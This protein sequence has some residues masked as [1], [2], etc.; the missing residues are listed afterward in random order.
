MATEIDWDAVQPSEEGGEAITGQPIPDASQIDWDSVRPYNPDDS[1]G[2]RQRL[3]FNLQNDYQPDQGS[4]YDQAVL[5]AGEGFARLPGVVGGLA[6]FAGA[7]ETGRNLSRYSQ[8]K[9]NEYEDLAD[10]LGT[11]PAASMARSLGETTAEFAPVAAAGALGSAVGGE[12][13]GRIAMSAYGG[14]QSL[15]EVFDQAQQAYQQNGLSESAA[16]SKARIPAA[17]AGAISAALNYFVPGGA[18]WV[19]ENLA[20]G[21]LSKTETQQILR[22]AITEAAGLSGLSASDALS[23]GVIAKLSYDPERTLKEIAAQTGMAALSGAGLGLLMSGAGTVSKGIA[24]RRTDVFPAEG[25]I[26]PESQGPT[27]SG[28][29]I[30]NYGP[31]ASRT[32]NRFQRAWDDFVNSSRQAW[33]DLNGEGD[34]EHADRSNSYFNQERENGANQQQGQSQSNQQGSTPRPEPVFTAEKT[35]TTPLSEADQP[36]ITLARKILGAAG[37]ADDFANEAARH[38]VGLFE[39][40]PMEGAEQFRERL[41]STL[42]DHGVRPEKDASRRKRADQAKWNASILEQMRARA[43]TPVG[44]AQTQTPL[45]P[46]QSA[47]SPVETNQPIAETR[48]PIRET[49]VAPIETR[50]LNPEAIPARPVETPNVPLSPADQFG[51]IHG[52]KLDP[53]AADRLRAMHGEFLTLP[54]IGDVE[55]KV[56]VSGSH[57]I[58]TAS[59]PVSKGSSSR[60]VGTAVL[61]I[62]PDGSTILD[63]SHQNREIDKLSQDALVKVIT[64]QNLIQ[65]Q[66]SPSAPPEVSPVAPPVKQAHVDW[67]ASTP[68][69]GVK[70]AGHYD[71]IDAKDL[72]TSF[73]RGFDQSLQPRDRARTASQQ[74]IVDIAQ[75]LDPARLGDA[76]T[77]DFGAPITDESNQVLSGNGRASALRRAFE[78]GG[79]QAASYRQW[80]SE[81]ASKFGID[82]AKIASV[83][84]PVLVR[85]V[86]DLGGLTK[87]QFA[88]QSNRQQ[89][90]GKSEAV[91]AASDARM[92]LSNP[93]LMEAFRPSE[94]GDVLAA[95]NRDFLKSFVMGTGDQAALM[96]RNE[97][98][99]PVLRKRVRNAV[100]GALIGPENRATITALLER[101]EELGLSNAVNGLMTAAPALLRLSGTQ[102]D[103]SGPLGKATQDLVRL[104]SEGSKV[105]DFLS[106]NDLFGDPDRSGESDLILMQ[107]AKSKSAKAVAE[108]LAK[109]ALRA[110]RIDTSTPDIFG[111][112]NP[113]RGEMLKTAYEQE[114]KPIS[115]DQ[116]D[117]PFGKPSP[118]PSTPNPPRENPRGSIRDQTYPTSTTQGNQPVLGRAA[119]IPEAHA[120]IDQHLPEAN[121]APM[122]MALDALEKSGLDTSKFILELTQTARDGLAGSFQNGLMR[123]ATDADPATGPEE[124]YHWMIESLPQADQAYLEA[125]RLATMPKDA[126]E[127]IRA[128]TMSTKEFQR[129]GLPEEMYPWI[130]LHEY[131][132]HDFADKT[133]SDALR[134]KN[135]GLWQRLKDWFAKLWNALKS[136]VRDPAASE[137]IYQDIQNGTQKYDPAKRAEAAERRGKFVTKKTELESAMDFAKGPEAKKIESE[138]ALAQVDA[139]VKLMEKHGVPDLPARVRRAL[140]YSELKGI[141]EVGVHGNGAHDDYYA[142]RDRSSDWLKQRLGVYAYRHAVKFEYDLTRASDDGATARA[143]LNSPEIRDEISEMQSRH[144]SALFYEQAFKNAQVAIKTAL[145][146]AMELLKQERAS[147]LRQA[148]LEAQIRTL[149]EVGESRIALERLLDDMTSVLLSTPQGEWILKNGGTSEDIGKIYRDIKRST[150]QTINS[151]QMI[152]VASYLLSRMPDLR[153]QLLAAEY[154]KQNGPLAAAWAKLK[155]LMD[156]LHKNPAATIERMM[157]QREKLAADA[158]AAEFIFRQ[159]AKE[160]TKKLDTIY[161]R[162]KTGEVARNILNDPEFKKYLLDTQRDSG[163]YGTEKPLEPTV[164]EGPGSFYVTPDNRRVGNLANDLRSGDQKVIEKRYKQAQADLKIYNEWL[165]NPANSQ[166]PR[167]EKFLMERNS[168]RDYWGDHTLLTPNH[169][170]NI[171]NT[172]LSSIDGTIAYAGGRVAPQNRKIAQVLNRTT[173]ATQIWEQKSLSDFQKTRIAGIKSHG[174][175]WND[176]TGRDMAWANDRYDA[177][178]QELA[179]KSQFRTGALKLGDKTASGMT[180]TQEDLDALATQSRLDGEGYKIVQKAD[181]QVTED[182]QGLPK[183]EN[184]D[185]MVIYRRASPVTSTTLPRIPKFDALPKAI[186]TATAFE[187]YVADKTPGNLSGLIDA[188][189]KIWP[190]HGDSLISHRESDFSHFTIFDGEGGAFEAVSKEISE[191]TRFLDFE[192]AALRIADISG[193]RIDEVRQIMAEEFGSIVANLVKELHRETQTGKSTIVNGGDPTNSFT[194]ERG[195]QL[196]PWTFYQT[197]WSSVDD[198][199]ATG[200]HMIS[201]ALNRMLMGLE[202]Q[203]SDLNRQ[204][205]DFEARTAQL[206]QQGAWHPKGAAQRENIRSGR[207]KQTFDYWFRLSYRTDA[208]RIRINEI[209]NHTTPSG[210]MEGFGY[211][212]DRYATAATQLLIS[213]E[214]TML[215]NIGIVYPYRA[216][217]AMGNSELLSVAAIFGIGTKQALKMLA[218]GYIPTALKLPF[219]TVWKGL[220]LGLLNSLKGKGVSEVIFKSV[221]REVWKELALTSQKRIPDV[222]EMIEAGVHVPSASEDDYNNKLASAFYRQ[223][224]K[225]GERISPTQKLFLSPL[226]SIEASILPV[227]TAKNPSMGDAVVNSIAWNFLHSSFSPNVVFK[228]KV[229]VLMKRMEKG[230]I[231]SW[232]TF[233]LKKNLEGKFDLENPTAANNSLDPWDLNIDTDQLSR[234]RQSFSQSGMNFDAKIVDFMRRLKQNPD[235]EFLSEDEIKALANWMIEQGNRQSATNRPN[236]YNNPNNPLVRWLGLL[237]PWQ[238][239]AYAQVLRFFSVPRHVP[240]PNVSDAMITAQKMAQWVLKALTAGLIGTVLVGGISEFSLENI[241]R[242]WRR[243]AYLAISPNRQPWEFEGHDKQLESAAKYAIQ[244]VPLLAMPVSAMLPGNTSRNTFNLTFVAQSK[245]QDVASWVSYGTQTGDWWYKTPSTVAGFYQDVKMIT[246]RTQPG[247]TLRKNAQALVQRYGPE[248]TLRKPDF[249]TPSNLSALSPYGQKLWDAAYRGDHREVMLIGREA[250]AA[251]KNAGKPDPRASVESLFRNGNFMSASLSQ[252]PSQTQYRQMMQRLSPAQQQL[253]REA[254][255]NYSKAAGWL[256]FSAPTFMRSDEKVEQT[257]MRRMQNQPPIGTT[258]MRRY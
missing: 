157:R 199:R 51:A 77:T 34:A 99:A 213:S 155:T 207:R 189:N 132:A 94:E 256:G 246:S 124:I 174:L 17:F 138:E 97:F 129:S 249:S 76:P 230:Y 47:P 125:E 171:F 148:Q 227:V 236:V 214:P 169:R 109:Y 182:T 139:P 206:S 232:K 95:S 118:V 140:G 222:A 105:E 11:S 114:S 8:D 112:T 102:Y 201:I 66:P 202:L 126:P 111:A 92:I 13:G 79:N 250:M 108:P 5:G 133:A 135:P 33:D 117:F 120:L 204:K 98:N 165:D 44:R 78:S 87:Q 65:S 176:L 150:S 215:R 70:V 21:F 75:R 209:K 224:P 67:Q 101:G 175:K 144:L 81:N 203:L 212:F 180:V 220:Y 143:E 37:F 96:S 130:N 3:N 141:Q 178:A 226:V 29:P 149:K 71:V 208:L 72:V 127:S 88:E 145:N 154:A 238:T 31:S 1:E 173:L 153:N 93:Q 62:L 134:A 9:V 14:L 211:V 107:T 100:L 168:I 233:G 257:N 4:L 247:L 228:R 187:A 218:Y 45:E 159:M 19:G 166:D 27:T 74:Q 160:L 38:F 16:A 36:R 68:I 41:F 131:A 237:M 2:L 57:I 28:E 35:R 177:H 258:R 162:I 167:Y 103:L 172:T 241:T 59:R 46:Q 89:V 161:T 164:T 83:K 217:S 26:A 121:R 104:K 195:K 22:H 197:G 39:P 82:P 40:N 128:G 252:L 7:Q 90:L 115:S 185:Q 147:D 113:S 251:A 196:G 122:H 198:V 223:I 194:Q 69:E 181:R 242:G 142:I 225:Q 183:R 158:T 48:A 91:S 61:S 190:V 240:F 106:Q 255:D 73:D 136:L 84:N 219:Y 253:I 25:P 248:D 235:A 6:R 216:I 221:T 43:A 156:Q 20:K 116:K 55:R 119:S 49:T 123:L 32:T 137:R 54:Q 234:W 86:S 200:G 254:E 152:G 10:T 231:R 42:R 163:A 210:S 243:V 15:G 12:Q 18:K 239:R 52:P 64:D 63:G 60:E 58:V 229:S 85:R 244:S 151:D 186:P 50:A 80:L 110:L 23:N 192:S 24:G 188:L 205:S 179:N 170:D 53:Q 193:R 191:G 245:I 184:G 30:P 146:E 56:K